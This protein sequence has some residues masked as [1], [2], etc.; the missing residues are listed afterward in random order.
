MANT[1]KGGRMMNA[2]LLNLYIKLQNLASREGGQDM[3][4][5]AL[6]TALHAFGWVVGV[7]S[8]ASAMNTAFQGIGTMLGS[9]VSWLLSS[10]TPLG[11]HPGFLYENPEVYNFG[12]Y[13]WMYSPL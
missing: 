2:L 11:H 8:T 1:R 3:V 4:E 13:G 9:Y 10:N 12:H 6:V 7:K 5:C